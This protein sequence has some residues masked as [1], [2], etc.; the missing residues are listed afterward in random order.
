MK[1]SSYLALSPLAGVVNGLAISEATKRPNAGYVHQPEP[2]P[3]IEFL[4]DLRH[5]AL[6]KRQATS[7]EDITYTLVNSPDS[8]CGFLSGSPGNAITCS[9]GEKCS[10]ELAH[11]TG[12]FCGTSAYN[13]CL[14]R[15]EALDTK[16]CND[17]CQSNSY[18]LLCTDTSAPFCG[19]YAYESG[20]RGFRCA[21]S[22]LTG[23]QSVSFLYNGQK[24]REL[25]TVY[26]SDE[27][28][29]TTASETTESSSE[30]KSST[31]STT[32]S[33]TTTTSEAPLPQNTG[34]GGG[35]KTNVGAIVG[36]AIGGFVVLSLIV[37][38]IIWFMRRNK[39]NGGSPPHQPTPAVVP[40]P[41]VP[42]TPADTVPPM[43]QHYSKSGVTSPT[44]SEW[45]DSMVTTQGPGS[46]VSNMT[47]T[48]QYPAEGQGVYHEMPQGGS[49]GR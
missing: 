26:V 18:N 37:L 8:T 9:N 5:L 20:V 49:Y 48:G 12:I 24:D 36:G 44:Q 46:P 40:Q 42:Q 2:T 25:S 47:W 34:G 27:V 22:T 38:G 35:S 16:L 10:W 15:S 17:V 28:T 3:M 13:R 45:R 31:T 14:D 30:E 11:V 41:H 32:T 23:E 29:T 33:A 39:K 4:D 19:T 6:G 7:T 21:S 43:S 1:I